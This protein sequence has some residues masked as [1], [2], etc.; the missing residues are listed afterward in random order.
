MRQ[1]DNTISTA[2]G[3]DMGNLLDIEN[4]FF[5]VPRDTTRHDAT[6]GAMLYLFPF[7]RRQALLTVTTVDDEALC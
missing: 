4:T 6:K 7:C 3:F 5:L 2:E 1:A